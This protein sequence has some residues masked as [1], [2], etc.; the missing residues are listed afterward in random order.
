[1]SNIFD[2]YF[3]LDELNE[4]SLISKLFPI[5]EAVKKLG[6]SNEFIERD[7]LGDYLWTV[8]RREFLALYP[9]N[10]NHLKPK[11]KLITLY[12]A[13]KLYGYN[14]INILYLMIERGSFD[15]I[16]WTDGERTL[17]PY[18]EA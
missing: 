3:T 13:S 16:L 9:K 11:G 6:I 8:R 10:K 5:K 4:K 15:Y 7:C 2:C 18:R 12:Q 14:S 17:I 1:M